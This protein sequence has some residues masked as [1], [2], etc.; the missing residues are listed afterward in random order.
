MNLSQ[1]LLGIDF[2]NPTV[3]A[4]GIM[5]ITS[6]SWKYCVENGAGAITTKSLWPA[7]HEGN[8]NPTIIS[9][10]YWTLNAVGVP[11]A[12]PEKAKEEIGNFMKEHPVPLIANIIGLTVED[13][14]EI[15]A[16][17][18]ALKPDMI[19]VNLS[20]PTF[21]KLRGKLFAE[22]QNESSK[23]LKAVKKEIGNIPMFVKLTPNV[24]TIGEIAKACVDAGADGITAIN[25]A[26]PGMAID[27]RSRMPILAA[28]KGGVSGRA[29]KPIAVRCVAEIYEATGGKTPIIGTGGVYTGEDAIE[30][31]LAGA[32]LVGVGTAVGDRGI[33][34]F[35]KICDEMQLW[36]TN[37][38]VD[39][40]SDMIGGMHKELLKRGVKG[41]SM[42]HRS[43]KRNE[44]QETSDKQDINQKEKKRKH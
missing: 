44:M 3:L 25:T 14:A 13:F 8:R 40:V 4:S 29:L 24:T 39:N 31:M 41:T 42:T 32:S 7:E 20:T 38:G 18:A 35:N 17:I 33:D 6:S 5:G 2:P 22:D 16:K 10:E 12:G 11:D 34:V 19:E 27:L 36:C 21:L 15:A 28:H 1:T 37:E 23:I 43:E 30:M 26:G 9:T